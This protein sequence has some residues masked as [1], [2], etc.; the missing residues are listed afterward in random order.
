MSD[1]KCTGGLRKEWLQDNNLDPDMGGDT[2]YIALVLVYKY[3]I[4]LVN[5]AT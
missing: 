5:T 4:V 1:L 3:S 2:G